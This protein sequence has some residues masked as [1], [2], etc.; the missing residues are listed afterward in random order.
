MLYGVERVVLQRG[1]AGLLYGAATLPGGLINIITKKPSEIASTRID[2][3]T[4]TYAGNGV[5]FG[6]RATFGAEL[7][8]TGPL[9][10]DGRVLYRGILAGD[11]SDHYTDDVI[12]KTRYLSASLTFKLDDEGRHTFTPLVQY[13]DNTRPAGAGFVISPS[14][15]LDANDGNSGPIN[16]SDLSPLDV[17]LY[18]G[19]RTDTILI[20]GF[21]FRSKPIEALAF[22]A[23]YRYIGYET[24]INQWTPQVSTAPQRAQLVNSNTV[25]R[26][27]AKS[28][29][30]RSSHNFDVNSTYEF[31]PTDWWK[32]LVQVGLNGRFY[33]SE[34]R[35]A[36][37]STNA[38]Q[39][40]I[41]IYTGQ[42]APVLDNSTG[43]TP[44]A[45]D[46]DFYW[47]TYFQNQAA[48]LD[49]QWVLTLGLGYGQQH[50]NDAPTREGDV[51]PTASLV[52]NPTRQLA[53]YAS[54]ATSYLPADPAAETF[55]G[56][57]GTFDP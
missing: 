5:D 8:S 57:T 28:E 31:E 7:D 19:G 17:N 27:Q 50:F 56:R 46:D 21:D 35:N 20:T 41:N 54:Y 51:T 2:L 12:N 1:P 10:K 4:G 3:T 42:A 16:T 18:G 49:E 26:T 48:F 39:S 36:T 15:S 13:S 34:S 37:F 43:W 6:D 14:T 23:G 40:P 30:D 24:D 53:L 25:S 9:T 45:L 55:D 29:A 32:D 33:R 52:F 11:N 38:P 47:N 44:T 22:N